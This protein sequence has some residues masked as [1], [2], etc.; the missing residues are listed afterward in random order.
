MCQP[1]PQ[2]P[3]ILVAVS[4]SLDPAPFTRSGQITLVLYAIH[5]LLQCDLFH[6]LPLL[7]SVTQ[8]GQTLQTTYPRLLYLLGSK[9]GS[10]NGA[11]GEIPEGGKK[12]EARCFFPSLCFG[13]HLQQHGCISC[14]VP[15]PTGSPSLYRPSV[16]LAAP[17]G[18]PSLVLHVKF[19]LLNYLASQSHGEATWRR[20]PCQPQPLQSSSVRCQTCE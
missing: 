3:S 15:A 7:C 6:D 16:S 20:I 2:P 8:G 11:T 18:H 12:R 17:S 19:P 9:L 4:A 5:C 1:I 14:G 10:A 13:Q